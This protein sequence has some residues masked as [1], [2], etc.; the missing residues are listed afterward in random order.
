MDFTEHCRERMKNFLNKPNNDEIRGTLAVRN[1]FVD[2][3][4]LRHRTA[5]LMRSELISFI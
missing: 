1:R 3:T 4:Y 5:F 2:P